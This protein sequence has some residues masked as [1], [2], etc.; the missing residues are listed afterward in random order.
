LPREISS[1]KFDLLEIIRKGLQVLHYW[2]LIRLDCYTLPVTTGRQLL[3]LG[4]R[5]M[6]VCGSPSTCSKLL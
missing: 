6:W 3:F 1:H 5:H 4:A 2:V